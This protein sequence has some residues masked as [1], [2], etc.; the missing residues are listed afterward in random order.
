MDK[1]RFRDIFAHAPVSIWE[2]DFSA[3]GKWLAALRERGIQD[4]NAFLRSEPK[5]LQHALSLVRIVEVNEITLR[6]WEIRSKEELLDRWADLFTDETYDVF[7]GELLAIWEGRNEVTFQCSARTATGRPIHYEMHWVAPM[8]DGQMNLRQVIVAI[9]DITRSKEKEDK[10]R[11]NERNLQLAGQ[12]AKIGYWSRNENSNEITWS[13][14]TCRIFGFE[15]Q[16]TTIKSTALR[17]YIHPEDHKMVD[18][19]IQ[20][21]FGGI[22][23]YDM[24]YRVLRPDGTMRWVHSKG[25]VYF[26]NNRQQ[27]RLIGTV[28]DITERKEAEKAIQGYIER[29]KIL[30]AMDRALLSIQ[31]PE[32][33]AKIALSHIQK[34]VPCQRASVITFPRKGDEPRVLVAVAHGKPQIN[35]A[36]AEPVDFLKASKAFEEGKTNIIP[37]LQSLRDPLPE[38]RTLR[39]EGIRS[40]VNVPIISQNRLIGSLNLGSEEP[41]A[42][43]RQNL[44]IAGEVAVLLGVALQNAHLMEE[45]RKHKEELKRY[46][47]W[48][49]LAQ[50]DER[51]RISQELHDEVGQSLTAISINLAAIR[52]EVSPVLTPAINEKIEDMS[53]LVD[54]VSNQLHE[55]SLTL[56]PSTLDDL[57]LVPSLRQLARKFGKIT[58]IA[59]NFQADKHIEGLPSPVEVAIY[60]IVQEALNNVAKHAEATEALVRITLRD[61][62]L[63]VLIQ[64]RGKGFDLENNEVSLTAKCGIGLIGMRERVSFMGGDLNIR[65]APGQGTRVELN[66]PLGECQQYESH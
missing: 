5:A 54:Q 53:S 10:L 2:E 23:P 17:A 20:D 61:D 42:F 56:R 63:K 65:T 36:V 15:P 44:E 37:D 13:V 52:K 4:L 21:A 59:I 31:S 18:Q 38:M 19:A 30:R 57:G 6:L 7:A 32:S 27:A 58:S 60:R 40:C 50:E 29:L 46:S 12:L 35:Q 1:F 45:I 66:L 33:I 34:L 3:V 47:T 8:V 62:T 55:L 14:E 49:I 39:M 43:H 25:E 9:I 11:E 51:K 26:D 41:E 24:E 64:D 22:R 48:L 28:L 16:T